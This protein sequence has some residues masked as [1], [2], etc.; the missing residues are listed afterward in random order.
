MFHRTI[1]KHVLNL[2][3]DIEN[4]YYSGAKIDKIICFGQVMRLLQT[5]THS[6]LTLL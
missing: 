2:Q 4:H 5:T 1:L 6:T 3:F